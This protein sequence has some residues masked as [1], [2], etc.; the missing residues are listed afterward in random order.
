MLPTGYIKTKQTKI[1]GANISVAGN[2]GS[3]KVLVKEA[4]L[5][6]RSISLGKCRY[7]DGVEGQDGYI[8][9]PPRSP[10]SPLSLL[11]PSSKNSVLTRY[12]K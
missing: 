4:M 2:K 12:H 9:A 5:L 7:G 3:E 8:D 1:T 11:L 10:A 6:S